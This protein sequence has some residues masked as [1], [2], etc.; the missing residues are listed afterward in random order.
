MPIAEILLNSD[1]TDELVQEY[2]NGTV[3]DITSIKWRE[4]LNK[5][6]EIHTKLKLKKSKLF[7][8]YKEDVMRTVILANKDEISGGFY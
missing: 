4:I 1:E 7:D 2:N 3:I 5:V 6:K 8:Q